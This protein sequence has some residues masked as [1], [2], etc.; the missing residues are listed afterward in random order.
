MST[1]FMRIA[2][3]LLLAFAVA[4]PLAACGKRGDLEEP[5]G[6]KTQFPRA[7]PR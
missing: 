2:L 1:K 7:M 5:K 3:A 6:E 4:A